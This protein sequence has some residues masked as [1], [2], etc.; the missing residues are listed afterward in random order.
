MTATRTKSALSR[1]TLL[2]GL[3][4]GLALPWLE[5]MAPATRSSL[6]L[7]SP[8]PAAR[9]LI[10]VY[11]PNGVQPGAWFP[12]TEGP[13]AELPP[14]LAPLSPYLDTLS[15]LGG[16]E[17]DKAKANGDGP[18]DHA[19]ASAAFLTGVQPLKADGQVHLGPSADQIVAD[20]L[21]GTTPMRSL[22]VGCEGVLRS[23][24]CDSGYACAYSTHIS[25][26]SETT[27]ALKEFRPGPL[28]DRL[29]RGADSE[30]TN[31]ERARR[32]S[33]LDFV[34]DDA[35][36]LQRRLGSA[37]RA[38]LDEFQT[39]LRDLE[40]RIARLA[41][42][43]AAVPDE[44]RPQDPGSDLG[45]QARVMSDLIALALAQDL[46][47]TVT[48]MLLNEGNNRPYRELEIDE[49]HHGLSHHKGDAAS[50]DKLARI[51][52]F[53]VEQL[54]YLLGRLRATTEGDGSLLDAAMVCYGSG[55]GDGNRHQHSELPI[56]LAGG[57]AGTLTPLGYRRFPDRTPLNDLHLALM[58]R[59]GVQPERFGDGRAP[60]DLRA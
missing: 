22:A 14:T 48:F 39:G 18:G 55:I 5:A 17:C 7:T 31:A 35:A 58:E 3:G 2:R 13:L 49:G 56:L 47:R 60:L 54:A 53:H 59:M 24:Q 16:L 45:E 21:A 27:P 19:R 8:D 10:Y 41:S 42:A 32:R 52:A 34:A 1:R 43:N 44:L 12:S 25:W 46:T 11:V 28:F 38:K 9:R 37:D 57:G 30:L 33:V 20:A 50:I 40:Q 36:R 51:E 6:G 29:F 4:V 15:V 26:R 23:G